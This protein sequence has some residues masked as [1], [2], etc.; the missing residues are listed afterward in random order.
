VRVFQTLLTASI[1][2]DTAVVAT[3]QTARPARFVAEEATIKSI[4]SAL[5]A[6]QTTCVD[7]TQA[8]LDRI[9][10]YDDKGPAL[11]AIIMVNPRAL[12]TAREMDR[13]D[14]T[15]VGRRPLHCIPVVLKDNYDT[16]DMPTT[17]GSVTL[18]KSI[19]AADGFVVKRLREAGA[20]ILAKANLMELAWSGTTVSSLGGQTRNPYDLTRTPGGSSGGTGAA[21]AANFGV[22]GTGSDTGQS[23][24]SPASANSLV[25]V[26]PTRGLVSRAGMIPLSTTQDAAG[27]ITRTVEDAARMLEVIAGYDPDDPSTAF[28]VGRIPASYSTALTTDGLKGARIGLLVDFLGREAVHAPVNTVVEAAASRMTALGATIVRVSIPS[29]DA[30]TR[31]LSLINFEFTSAFNAYLAGLGPR[32]PVKN[33]DEFIA[34]GEFHPALRGG[35]LAAQKIAD[36]TIVP[37]Y[38]QMRLR[39][40]DLRQAVM[41]LIAGNRLDAVLYPHQRRLVVPIGEEQVERNGVLSN[42]TGFPAVT[43]PA[44]FS[45]PTPTAPIG[46]PIGL[47]ILG[48]EWSEPLLLKLAFAYQEGARARRTPASAPPLR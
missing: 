18:A 16:H 4:Q 6:G 13:L 32:A 27:P 26:R 45:P 29:L 24:R 25:G 36:P 34:R 35:L 5:M 22:L 28:S 1:L 20:L 3:A 47:E 8:Y 17:G 42:S 48:P 23:I 38:Q 9:E 11:N 30:L 44:G 33:L 41:T 2:L 39:R 43:F 40:N 7:V 46:V 10:A 12:E 21:I 37:E 15:E 31:D 19:P 14:A